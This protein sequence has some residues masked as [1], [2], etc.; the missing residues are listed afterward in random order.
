MN[1]ILLEDFTIFLQ[2]TI[3]I[4]V[5]GI[6]FETGK[7]YTIFGKSGTGKTTFLKA[8]GSL[9]R[10]LGTAKLNGKNFNSYDI[11]DLRKKVHYIR[12]EPRFIP[13]TVLKN[14]NYVFDFAANKSN[15]NNIER[16]KYLLKKM[17]LN[18]D[19]LEKDTRTLSGGEKQRISIIRSL[20]LNP[21]FILLDEPTSALDIY[22]EELLLSF[23]H[24][25]KKDIG[26]IVVSHSPNIIQHSDC[27]IL[28]DNKKLHII[29][30]ELS[31]EEIKKIIEGEN[32][33]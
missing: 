30:G 21:S 31:T 27:K 29:D 25:L 17:N 12:Q 32:G 18:D 14:I 26:I 10:F 20:L 6:S 15:L 16:T 13:D 2:G 24:D 9:I 22:T 28:L 23:L 11:R 4:H 1:T 3:L 19:I 5:D 33:R 7:I 8:L